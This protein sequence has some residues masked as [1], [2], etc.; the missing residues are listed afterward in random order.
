MTSAVRS[1]IARWIGFAIGVAA[2]GLII[3][4]FVRSGSRATDLIEG[5]SL[6]SLSPALAGVLVFHV[7]AAVTLGRVGANESA[8]VWAASQLTKYLPVPASAAVGMLGSSVRAGHTPRG[9]LRILVVHSI[10]LVGAATVVGSASAG[11]LIGGRGPWPP[12][13]LAV[14]VLLTGFAITALVLWSSTPP[15]RVVTGGVAV[16]G[17]A[18]VAVGMGASFA[19]NGDWRTGLLLGSAYCAAWVAGQIVVPVP[20]GLGV[21]EAALIA[22]LSSHV[23]ATEA[24]GF[25]VLSRA[26]HV[27]SD[28]V[29]AFVVLLVWPAVGRDTDG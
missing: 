21:R 20:A 17:W 8:G 1:P 2:F 15:A 23:G 10:L 11:T 12:N 13:W 16:A 14:T 22:I 3:V 19:P 25:A 26:I 18:A 4:T 7:A 29:I 5:R 6:L 28:G 24:L 9:A 27:L